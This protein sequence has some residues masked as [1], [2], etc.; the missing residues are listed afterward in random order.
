M[1]ELPRYRAPRVTPQTGGGAAQRAQA[2]MI[3]SLADRI[4]AFKQPVLQRMARTAEVEAKQDAAEAFS[5]KGMQA[6][7]NDEMTIY[8]QTYSNA[9]SGM[10][11]K[12]L[13]IDTGIAFEN[14]YQKNKDNP[15]AFEEE[16]K[17]IYNKTSELLPA[18]LKAD[19]AIDFE[20]N[21][22]HFA[23][24]VNRNRIKLDQEKD[25]ALTNE[26]FSQSSQ[27]A[28]R[29]SREGN[30]ELALYEIGKGIS[31]LDS[32]LENGTIKADTH[33]KKVAK[34]KYDSSKAMFKGVNDKHIQD[35]DIEGSQEFIDSFRTSSVEGY[36]DEQ[37]E[38]LADEMQGEL[39]QTIRQEGVK[40]KVIKTNAGIVV[41]DAKKIYNSGKMP[42]NE[43]AAMEASF[44]VTPKQKWEL[45]VAKGAYEVVRK[46]DMHPLPE[47]RALVSQMVA[48]PDASR[49]DIEIISQVKKNISK[50]MALAEKDPYSLGVE[51]GLYEQAGVIAPSMGLEALVQNLPT[52]AAQSK[53]TEAAYGT[54]RKLFT[55][56]EAQQYSAWLD[57]PTTSISDKLDFIAA[58]EASVPNDSNLVYDQLMKKG[59]SVVAFAGSMV[60][61]GDRQKAEKMLR[62]Q[63]ILREQPNV[64]PMDIMQWKFNG[65]VGNAMR[66][67]GAGMRKSLTDATV[68]YYAAI[69]EEQ[70]EL[71]KSDAPM[72][73]VKQAVQEVTGG[74]G[75][76]NDQNYFLP[77]QAT[78]DDVDDWL[79]DLTSKDFEDVGGITSENA[80]ELVS[81]GQLVSVGEGKYQVMFQGNRLMRNDNTP[82]VLEY[83]K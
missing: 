25:L 57:S 49:L 19:Y 52:R 18:H 6:E 29:A 76:K 26:L 35:G 31:A 67:Q 9:L 21:K 80:V 48:D 20:A 51:E 44:L 5:Q 39:N 78:E 41:S 68:A 30:H 8:G 11:K 7:V 82:F 37:R 72:G 15:L 36:S 69:A 17:E 61:K 45:D 32:A 59:S 34:I 43:D 4:G 55:D 22:A 70:G 16:T 50:K 1:A 42:T 73:L 54:T 38:S 47:Q 74:V 56:A 77:P 3:G 71:S 40:N 28:S 75:I 63:M 33:I 46:I 13:A 53:A 65:E 64:V 2:Q 81:R 83:S 79:D 12:Q 58:V 23:G 66:Y 10:H 24:Q 62:G 60:K 14:V 27:S